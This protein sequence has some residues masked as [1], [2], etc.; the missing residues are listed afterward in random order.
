MRCHFYVP[1]DLWPVNIDEG[2]VSQA[3]NNLIINADQA[4]PEGGIIEV[5]A[6][7]VVITKD[8][9][10]PLPPG[11]YLK[12]S[13]KDQG[14][15]IPEKYLQK[16]YDPYFTTKQRGSGL[17]LA[18]TYSIIR[19][20]D[21]YIDLESKVGVGTIFYMW[22]PA[23]LKE[24]EEEEEKLCTMVKGEGRVLLMDDEECILEAAGEALQYLGYTVDCARDGQE[25]IEKYKKELESGTPFDV[26]VM[27]LTIPGGMGG[28]EALQML[29]EIDPDVR[30]IVSSGYST[31][32]VMAEYQ[33][34]GFC[35]VVTKP[36]SIEELSATLNKVLK[37]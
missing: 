25:A 32:Q 19:K 21:G 36:Y 15:G 24:C 33:K 8:F 4:M 2:Q 6:E 11:E 13:I 16:I 35:G 28:K 27:D 12:I 23:A 26:V 1:D 3:I 29:R 37:E 5:R 31:S 9:G 14:V 22:L 34:H 17:G 7:N 10:I 20:H 18:T 30:A